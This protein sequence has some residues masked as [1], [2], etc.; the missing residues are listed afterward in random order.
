[1]KRLLNLACFTFIFTM[2]TCLLFGQAGHDGPVLPK[3][4]SLAWDNTNPD[5]VVQTSRMY[6]SRI[7]PV[8][9]DPLNLVDEIAVTSLIWPIQLDEKQWY[10]A[11]SFYDGEVESE[12]SNEVAFY[13]LAPPLNI[14]IIR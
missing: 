14:R 11:V 13:I 7:S 6:C 1:M 12:L 8:V 2:L 4:A 3:T 10:C 5:G 9:Q